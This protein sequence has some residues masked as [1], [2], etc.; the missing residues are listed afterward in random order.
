[1]FKLSGSVRARLFDAGITIG[2]LTLVFPESSGA[3]E[4]A[5]GNLPVGDEWP[6]VNGE[7]TRGS[8]EK[9]IVQPR[10][11]KNTLMGLHSLMY[12]KK[13]TTAIKQAKG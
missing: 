6:P 12:L 2:I 10:S 3:V 9:D 7:V 11:T 8:G 5:A 13:Q 1:M 4:V